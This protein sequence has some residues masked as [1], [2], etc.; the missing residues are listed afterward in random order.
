MGMH[1]KKLITLAVCRHLN[2]EIFHI[3]PFNCVSDWWQ[4]V[5]NSHGTYRIILEHNV[6]VTRQGST[7][8]S[9][10]HKICI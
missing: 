9:N 4:I 3:R 10:K 7:R 2:A 6:V 1:L 5:M 8:L